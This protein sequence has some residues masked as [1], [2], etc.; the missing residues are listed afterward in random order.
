MIKATDMGGAPGGLTGTG[1]VEIKVEDI[2][3]NM[4]DLEKSEVN[5]LVTDK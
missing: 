2:N 5:E 3:D 1:T 4:P